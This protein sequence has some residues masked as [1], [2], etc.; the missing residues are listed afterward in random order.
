MMVNT[1]EHP[2]KAKQEFLKF[3]F[4]QGANTRNVS[5]KTSLQL[6]IYIFNSVDKTELSF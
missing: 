5:F 6:P 3:F 4:Y 2:W 1:W